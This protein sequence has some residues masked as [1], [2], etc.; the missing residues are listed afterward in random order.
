MRIFILGASETLWTAA[1]H[2]HL[3]GCGTVAGVI[4]RKSALRYTRTEADFRAMAD[5]LGAP[6]LVREEMDGE[7][8]RL[9]EQAAADVCVTI[10][11]LE[12]LAGVARRF[13]LGAV[14]PVFGNPAR[15]TGNDIDLWA[16][17]HGRQELDLSIR[18]TDPGD[19]RS[20]V[21]PVSTT[22]SLDGNATIADIRRYSDSRTPSL[23]G[24]AI[25]W[26]AKNDAATEATPV[27][28]VG[29]G[30]YHPLGG[31]D[32]LIDWREP[33]ERIHARIKAFTRP[34]PG[35]YTY[36]RDSVGNL[37]KLFVWRSRLVMP[38]RVEY[39]PPGL[40]IQCRG[41]NGEAQVLTG[42]GILALQ[43]VSEGVDA[44]WF[45]PG[46]S[47]RTDHTRLG[48]CLEDEVFNLLSLLPALKE[49]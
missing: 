41:D 44:P 23:V 46:K 45:E 24:E 25:A 17:L 5:E 49:R 22:I 18:H 3:T 26:L 4:T 7:A 39:G 35:A 2:L 21:L 32:R 10:D 19:G 42:D 13:R 14:S 9:V 29:V 15:Q 40:V 43:A 38:T 30:R 47:W 16:I 28:D 11:W 33:A 36:M 8:S 27:E 31:R 48:L 20:R 37:V 34:L 6:F 12:P 1:R